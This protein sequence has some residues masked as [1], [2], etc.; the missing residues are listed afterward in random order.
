MP[1]YAILIQLLPAIEDA[2]NTIVKATPG[3]TA[4]QATA[5][6]VNHLTPGQPNSETLGPKS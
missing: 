4:Q 6:L 3:L 5:Q 2:I 1:W